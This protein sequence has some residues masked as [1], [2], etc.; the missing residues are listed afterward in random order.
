MDAVTAALQAYSDRGVFRS[1][2]ATPAARARV[3]YQFA[4]LTRRPLDAVFDSRTNTLTFPA[5]LPT[6][7]KAA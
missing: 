2:R 5:L 4:W 1:F 7:G 6:L 3:T